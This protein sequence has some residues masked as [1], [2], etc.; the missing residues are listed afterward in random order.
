MFFFYPVIQHSAFCLYRLKL[1][2][3]LQPDVASRLIATRHLLN[4]FA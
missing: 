2:Y 3:C 1:I 4:L